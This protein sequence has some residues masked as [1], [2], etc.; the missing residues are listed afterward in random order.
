[1]QLKTCIGAVCA[2]SLTLLSVSPGLAQTG[3]G[4]DLTWNSVDG[5]AVTFAAGNGYELGAAIGQPD[6]QTMG[7]NGYALRGG[8]WGGVPPDYRAFVP[9][10]LRGS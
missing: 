1:M 8:F 9:V 10:A 2:L 4:Y 3:G 5:G 7:G 6:A